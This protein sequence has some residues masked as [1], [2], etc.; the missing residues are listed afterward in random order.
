MPPTVKMGH[1]LTHAPQQSCS[2]AWAYSINSFGAG[3]VAGSFATNGSQMVRRLKRVGEKDRLKSGR[4]LT[5]LSS[6]LWCRG[7]PQAGDEI[8][9]RVRLSG[10]WWI[11]ARVRKAGA[12]CVKR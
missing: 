12:R 11:T 10:D 5:I 6:F 4:T 9:R 8:V 3:K 1:E 7:R 2:H